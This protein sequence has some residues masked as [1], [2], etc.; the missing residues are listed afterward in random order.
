MES[1]FL[2]IGVVAYII[3]SFLIGLWKTKGINLEGFIASRNS[4]G[5]WSIL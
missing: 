1:L 5:F 4:I 2:I 3:I